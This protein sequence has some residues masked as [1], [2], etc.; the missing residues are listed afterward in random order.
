MIPSPRH[1]ARQIALHLGPAASSSPS[2]H[3][4]VDH[5]MTST[6]AK[7][8]VLGAGGGIG[9]P[10]A[11]PGQTSAGLGGPADVPG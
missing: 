7:V 6:K 8:A 5:P 2:H 9:Q 3:N 4:Q 11:F 10:R 1:R